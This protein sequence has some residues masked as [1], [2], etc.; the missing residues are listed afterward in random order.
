MA[1]VFEIG[2]VGCGYLG[3]PWGLASLTSATALHASTRMR[4]ASR[5]PDEYSVRQ[6]AE[7]ILEI[8]GSQSGIVQGPLPEDD[9]KE[10]RPDITRARETLGWEPRVPAEEGLKLTFEWFAQSLRPSEAVS[11]AGQ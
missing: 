9:P 7:I 3:S 1:D 8:S 2:I 10:R 4:N 6:V 5:D 11:P